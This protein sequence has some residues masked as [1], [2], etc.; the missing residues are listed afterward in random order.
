L[1]EIICVDDGSTDGTK[2]IIASYEH[3]YSCVRSV[4]HKENQGTLEARRSGSL[5]AT[6]DYIL[7]LDPDDV[8]IPEI[9][10]RLSEEL[11]RRQRDVLYFGFD[12]FGEYDKSSGERWS[13]L[14]KGIPSFKS[15]FS[16]KETYPGAVWACA[17]RRD[18]VLEA[19]EFM[20]KGYCIL[21]DDGVMLLAFLAFAK[22]VECIDAVGYKY[23][24]G[25]GI[26]AR[27]AVTEERLL[28]KIR[29]V[30]YVSKFGPLY[31]AR[32]REY[33][34]YFDVLETKFWDVIYSELE[35]YC[36]NV[37]DGDVF[38]T[39]AFALYGEAVSLALM[40]R[41]RAFAGFLREL[42]AVRFVRAL[43]KM[44]YCVLGVLM[45]L[46]IGKKDC[47]LRRTRLKQLCRSLSRK[48]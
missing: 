13:A 25:C 48:N 23:R 29:S 3:A 41:E 34:C 27:V 26:T 8:L 38:T 31:K 40:K 19:F 44:K 45:R 10:G 35:S 43:C 20:P 5:V 11:S 24:L 1:I 21:S 30:F 7:Y 47:C 36:A 18:L 42:R 17:W 37:D 33:S 15:I 16:Q 4:L 39:E 14:R 12:I 46:G 9:V 22:T 6:G 32:F 28:K 2:A